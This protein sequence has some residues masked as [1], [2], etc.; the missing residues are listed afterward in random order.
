MD[1]L[2]TYGTVRVGMI[3][4]E[5]LSVIIVLYIQVFCPEGGKVWQ[6][7]TC[8]GK[9]YKG[10]KLNSTNRGNGLRKER[11]NICTVGRGNM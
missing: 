10:K 9:I 11:Q 7:L 6:Y 1:G 3:F 2:T 8:R 4:R 5:Q